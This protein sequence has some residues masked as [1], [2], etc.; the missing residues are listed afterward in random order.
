MFTGDMQEA[1]LK[2]AF[3]TY[4]Q[5]QDIEDDVEEVKLQI[6]NS[7][8]LASLP[9]CGLPVQQSGQQG[10]VVIMQTL[11]L[12]AKAQLSSPFRHSGTGLCGILRFGKRIGCQSQTKALARLR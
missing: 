7:I 8:A 1:Q 3:I 6:S 2:E 12:L 4:E 9:L 5:L 10:E 11:K